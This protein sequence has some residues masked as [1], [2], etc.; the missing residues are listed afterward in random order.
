[1]ILKDLCHIPFK[2]NHRHRLAAADA[3]GGEA[4]AP[5]SPMQL[6]DD[7]RPKPGAAGSDGMAE[8]AGAAIDV[9]LFG[10]SS[11]PLMANERTGQRPR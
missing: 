7:G 1:M 3:E 9:D 8:G 10:R 4:I 2:Y 11:S 6:T 5:V